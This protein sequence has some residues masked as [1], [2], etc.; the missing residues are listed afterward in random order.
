VLTGA[1]VK[2][3]ICE[4]STLRYELMAR[5]KMEKIVEHLRTEV[6][7]ALEDAV[8]E[9]LP[10]AR[11]DSDDLYRAFRRA[12]GRKCNTWERVPDSNVDAS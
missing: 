5:V 10:S 1:A 2:F 3:L 4:R 7:R 9:V 11:V 6:K 8:K 12:I